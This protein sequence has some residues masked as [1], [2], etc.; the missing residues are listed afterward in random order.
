VLEL[1]FRSSAGAACALWLATCV[2]HLA[3]AYEVAALQT[4]T[5]AAAAAV[6][7]WGGGQCGMHHVTAVVPLM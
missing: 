3:A 4:V 2:T 7:V 1:Q 5:A 6:C